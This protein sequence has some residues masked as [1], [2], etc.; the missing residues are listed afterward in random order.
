M[1]VLFRLDSSRVIGVGHFRRCL[2]LARSLNSFG[3]KC[4]FLMKEFHPEAQES[5]RCA[6]IEIK[7]LLEDDN[8]KQLEV[9]SVIQKECP[10]VIILDSYHLGED[11]LASVRPFCKKLMVIDELDRTFS[12]IDFLLDQSPTKKKD[13]FT[14]RVPDYC[15][16]LVGPR[17]ILIPPDFKRKSR[18]WDYLNLD[19][20]SEM[21]KILICF[22]GSDQSGKVFEILTQ[23]FERG[24][25]DSFKFLIILNN[26]D[27]KNQEISSF[28]SAKMSNA[29]VTESVEDISVLME[30]SDFIISGAGGM[31]WERC[32]LGVAGGVFQIADNQKFNISAVRS[33]ELGPIF[34]EISDLLNYLESFYEKK[35]L[36]AL[37]SIS[38]KGI[39]LI[40]GMGAQR[41]ACSIFKD[42]TKLIQAQASDCLFFYDLQCKPGIREFS[43]NQSVPSL[44]EHK[45]WF[46]KTMQNN[47][48][49]KLFKIQC[50]DFAVGMIRLDFDREFATISV[51]ID[52]AFSGLGLASLSLNMLTGL[53]SS[54]SIIAYVHKKNMTSKLLFQRCNFIQI[55]VKDPYLIYQ[56]KN[57][58]HLDDN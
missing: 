19:N 43:K 54:I 10:D 13:D 39:S 17:F 24:L 42:T 50:G 33:F 34:D 41:V 55:D 18:S 25:G 15:K 6:G 52:P 32:C 30:N 49:I 7:V 8:Q 35:S 2:T 47:D 44:D 11:W 16:L 28:A 38:E 31:V 20:S 27:S 1:K 9:V 12:D 36:S 22:G 4:T 37:N 53:Y 56:Y 26:S 51:A 5:A 57:L 14:G 46:S 45:A 23:I 58:E 29:K 40:D 3:A 21:A 48:V